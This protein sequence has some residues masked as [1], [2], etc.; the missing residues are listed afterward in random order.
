MRED[1]GFSP[2][3]WWKGGWECSSEVTEGQS[4]GSHNVCVCT[5]TLWFAKMIC[6][7]FW[8]SP[9][10]PPVLGVSEAAFKVS[11]L[12]CSTTIAVQFHTETIGDKSMR[13][14]IDEAVTLWYSI[15]MIM[16]KT[17]THK[18]KVSSAGTVKCYNITVK[19]IPH[20]NIIDKCFNII[21]T[22]LEYMYQLFSS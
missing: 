9:M 7:L 22:Q 1:L 4:L 17:N 2:G 18:L 3:G 12:R 8:N 5:V 16:S 13:S 6:G 14:L 15:M 21:H 19:N 10:S 20:R 11:K